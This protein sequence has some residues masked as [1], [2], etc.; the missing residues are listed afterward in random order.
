MFLVALVGVPSSLGLKLY[1]GQV[2]P[3]F[4]IDYATEII[5]LLLNLAL[6]CFSS[7]KA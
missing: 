7:I 5:L 6:V 1:Q 2:E 3:I 4:T